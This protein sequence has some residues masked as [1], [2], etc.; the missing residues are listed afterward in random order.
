M[1]IS[2]VLT[3]HQRQIA[4]G[5]VVGSVC[6]PES[7]VTHSDQMYAN[8][9]TPGMSTVERGFWLEDTLVLKKICIWRIFNKE[10]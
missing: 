1:I 7:V 2:I 8:A 5:R 9:H 6:P 4:R 10:S 3:F